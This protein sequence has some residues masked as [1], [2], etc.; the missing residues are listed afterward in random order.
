MKIIFAYSFF[1]ILS[2]S[3][4]AFSLP[5]TGGFQLKEIPGDTLEAWQAAEKA[6]HF[7]QEKMYDSARHFYKKAAALYKELAMPLRSLDC[8]THFGRTYFAEEHYKESAKF[9]ESLEKEC[10]AL[11]EK[12]SLE[13][14]RFYYHYGLAAFYLHET[15]QALELLTRAEKS[16]HRVMGADFMLLT[17]VYDWI[18]HA[19]KVKM[20]YKNA[21]RYFNKEL[22]LFR[23][24]YGDEHEQLGLVYFWIGYMYNQLMDYSISTDYYKKSLSILQLPDN[25]SS[26]QIASMNNNIGLAY[27]DLKD[28]PKAKE[29]LLEAIRIRKEEEGAFSAAALAINHNILGLIYQE[30]KEY[31]FAIE[32]FEESIRFYALLEDKGGKRP[33]STYTNLARVYYN[34]KEFGQALSYLDTA[35]EL[36]EI[37]PKQ[38]IDFINYEPIYFP[39]Y[40]LSAQVFLALEEH[41]KALLEVE[42]VIQA[43]F[44]TTNIQ[45]V[46][47]DDKLFMDYN[48]VIPALGIKGDILKARDR[49]LTDLQ[50][51][52]NHYLMAVRILSV[53]NKNFTEYQS[54]SLLS[55]NYAEY[56]E[57][58]MELALKL[59][60]KEGDEKYLEDILE[61]M[62][63]NK[64]N[65]LL[66]SLKEAQAKKNADIP[67][68][69]MEQEK[70]LLN[71]LASLQKKL[72]QTISGPDSVDSLQV[73]EYRNEIFHIKREK[74]KLADYFEE[75][76]PTYHHAKY[77]SSSLKGAEVQAQLLEEEALMLE[78]FIGEENIFIYAISKEDQ[79]VYSFKKK[80]ATLGQVEGLIRGLKETDFALYT[81]NAFLLYLNFLEPVLSDFPQ[82][83]KLVVIPDGMLS[84]IPFESL[85]SRPAD[86]S[87]TFKDLAYLIKDFEISYH[88]S[89]NLMAFNSRKAG[90]AVDGEPGTQGFM[91]FAPDFKGK[92]LPL[93]AQAGG[94]NEVLRESLQPLPQ[95]L[96][97][98]K[99]I[100]ALL[101]G[102]YF[103]GEEVTEQAFKKHSASA[104]IIHLATH[105]LL[106]EE[107][108]AYSRLVFAD[109]Q[110]SDEDGFLHIYEIYNMRLN[111]DLVCLS[112]CNTGLGKNYKGEGVMSL[113]R[114]FMYA[115]VPNLMM[116]LWAVPDQSTP[117]LMEYFYKGIS[118]GKPK[119]MAL[120]EAKLRYLSEA[121][122]NTANPYYWGAFVYVGNVEEQPEEGLFPAFLAMG[123]LLLV[124]MGFG[125]YVLRRRKML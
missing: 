36:L 8:K 14:G 5:E 63:S 48:D 64:S 65:I 47:L 110:E 69:F 67:D 43:F 9:F 32:A 15:E 19:Y 57:Q 116:S 86:P 115:G 77:Q 109:S 33:A 83:Q 90:N 98:V 104:G 4:Y 74:E 123:I 113:A 55:R 82:K 85:I 62:E 20:Q 105:A 92:D 30:Q 97:E 80:A 11:L 59:Y 52:Y 53:L 7:D 60:A 12:E 118:Q 103:V 89:A 94:Q 25:R 38:G 37:A 54:V 114:S 68:T 2:F 29:H 31:E 75:E 6:A 27:Y 22:E 34:Q 93:L 119:P 72:Y 50:D 84:Y 87:S 51:A 17:D 108:P 111:A 44:K 46:E 13:K 49:E 21:I 125:F 117:R 122:G 28:Y 18:A 73:V 23:R 102:S 96:R 56:Y 100:S 71:Q 16:L 106:N 78:Y 76:I 35:S 26:R 101:G 10:A 70:Q 99:S 61:V 79:K 24:K 45:E 91:G 3:S 40:N 42:K 124:M 58:A 66:S 121:D 41:E 1:L 95:A 120:R 107:Y 88:Y 81:E 39:V 112:A